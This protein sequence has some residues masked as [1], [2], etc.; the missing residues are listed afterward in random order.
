VVG[1]LR[2]RVVAMV[3]IARFSARSPPR[4]R[5]CRTVRPLL[6][7]RGLVPARA[8]KAASFRHRR[9]VGEADD[10]LGGA[11]WSDA[12]LVGQAGSQIVHNGLQLRAVGL[13][14]A[15]GLAQR[16]GESPDLSVAHGLFAA[17][18]AGCSAPGHAGQGGVGE[19]AACGLAVGVIA[20]E[21]QCPQSIGLPRYSWW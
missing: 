2:I 12:A 16:E 5:R 20:A 15:G 4:L 10:H 11:E 9:R 3:W 14:R 21:Q 13:E 1:Q 18:V 19:R 6:A 17:G 7:C 8:A